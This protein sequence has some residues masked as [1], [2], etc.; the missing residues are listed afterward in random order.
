MR[1]R[2]FA[3]FC[4][5]LVT[6]S[7][8]AQPC[9]VVQC[10]TNKSVQCG[11]PWT[12]DLPTATTCCASGIVTSNGTLTNV[13]ITSTGITSNGACPRIDYT[14]TWSLVDGCG[15]STNCSQTVTVLG[16]CT[17][18]CFQVQCPT[19]KTVQ[20]GTT[21]TFDQPVATTCCTALIQDPVTGVLT[22]VLVV[23]TGTTTNGI[24]P[25]VTV[26]QTWAIMDGCGNS[27]NCTQ[28]VTITGCCNTCLQ[29]QCANSKNV[30]CGTPWTFDVPVATSCCPAFIPGTTTNVLIT[31]TTTQTNGACPKLSI[32][33][34][35]VINDAC[36]N[37]TNCSQTVTV[38]GCCPCLVVQCPTNK[39]VQCGTAWSFDLPVVTTCCT[40]TIA[41]TKTNILVTPGVVVSNGSCPTV[42]M[43]ET[44]SIIDG[45]GNSTNCSQTVTV[46]GC[47]NCLVVQC[48]TNKS[49][50]CGTTW[51]FDAPVVS[52]CCTNL[53]QTSAG[54]LTNVL[55]TPT[56]VVSNGT[57]PTV[58]MTESWSIMDGCGNTTNCSQ[59]VTVLGCCNCLQVQCSTNKSVQCGTTWSFDLPVVTSCCTSNIPGT[60]TNILITPLGV[61]SNG[62]CPTVTM[63][64][65]W[66][67]MDGCGNH[68]NCSQTVTVLGCCNCLQLQ[69]PTNKSVQCGTAWSFDLPVASSCC[70]S[71]ISGTTTNILIVPGGIVTNGACPTVTQTETWSIFDGCGNRTNCSQTVTILGC[72]NCLV[73][74]CPTNK[75]VQ[76]GTVWSFNSPVASTCCSNNIA[77]TTT[78]LLV[79]TISQTT[80]GTCPKFITKTWQITDGCGNTTNCSQVVTVV[81]TTPPVIVCPSNTIVVSLNSNCNLVIPAIPVTATDNCTPVC[82][83]VYTQNPPAGTIFPGSFTCVTVTVTDLCGNS[84][85]CVVC[86]LGLPRTPPTVTCPATMTVTNCIVP[87]VPVTASAPCCPHQSLFI[88]QSPPCGTTLGPGITSI[89]VTVIDCHG[90]VTTKVVHLIISSAQSF[91]ANLTNTGVGPGGLLLPDNSV[92]PYYAL[93]ASA[94][95]AGMPTDYHSNSV[96]VS[97]LCH[98]FN[99]FP[100]SWNPSIG[101][102]KFVPWNLPPDPATSSLAVSKWIAPDYTNCG[103]DPAGAYTYTLTFTLPAG[104]NP[105]TATISGRWAADDAAGITLNGTPI[106]LAPTAIWSWTPF[107]IP[108]GVG[109]VTGLNTLKFKVTN[110]ISW[111]G[112]RVEFTN[113]VANCLTC[114]PPS[115]ISITPSQSLPVGSTAT[116]N[117]NVGGTGP[118]TYQ[119]SHNNIPIGGAT[120]PM[121]QMFGI[122]Y[123]NAGLYSVVIHGPCGVVT[124]YV[125]LR[126][127]Y[128]WWWNWGWWNVASVASPLGATFGPS[129]NLVGS[130]VAATY[131]VNTGSTEDFGLPAPGGQ[132]V[133]VMEVNPEAG[134]SIQIPQITEAGSSNDPSYTVIMD[135]YEPDTSYGTSSTLF[136]SIACCVSNLGSGG[137]DGLALTLDSSNYLH[138]TGSSGGVPFD[139]AASQP[140]AMDA[141][142]RLALVVDNP[143]GGGTATMSLAINGG[144]III[145]N[146][147]ICCIIPYTA[148]TINWNISAPTVLTAPTTATSPN[149]VF[150]VSSI[151]FHDIALTPDMIAGIGSPDQGPAPANQTSVGASPVLTA[152]LVAGNVNLTWSGSPYALQETTDLSSGD[153]M[154]SQVP[155]TE[156]GNTSGNIQ[157]TAIATP[158]APSKFYRLVFRP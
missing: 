89:T 19:N 60:T 102:Y 8:L 90:N 38:L 31:P 82:S 144:T 132:A 47:C 13:L 147:C 56:G 12:F 115:I 96:A 84:S 140:M 46:L 71:N 157:T 68:T 119:W 15:N 11:T 98:S 41:G 83:L 113:A 62:A 7:G 53:I 143:P 70:T 104:Y 91:L 136:Q 79:T 52:T 88:S 78:N 74:Q 134:A 141:W 107:T 26:T 85:S 17:S 35:W 32:T 48:P 54:T 77:G 127:T 95:P 128:P 75:T 34:N 109:F 2:V 9:F 155:Y 80:N 129:L 45:C 57:C 37:T 30:Q 123:A 33:Q 36:G 108:P 66:S 18:N 58:T 125:N 131:G 114:V 55:V 24:C 6:I 29:V 130:S 105:A 16:C 23:P 14:Q 92:D 51:A 49:V 28:V 101:C 73:V 124:G 133:N 117:V 139:S 148:S 1:I 22:N 44:W 103:C 25:S 118:F 97:D 120:S 39:S 81:D 86:V 43:T 27:T 156:T 122:G 106:P 63:T 4:Y 145:I 146:P 150:F 135:V 142:N 40:S 110:A 126:V 151:Q 59:T 100:C 42:T 112:L 99:A 20:C 111:S 64:Q 65:S 72:C 116:F 158:S 67:I 69:C 61:V 138:L 76:C 87:C 50:Q 137:Q 21:W 3:F 5:I 10:S 121:L 152:A 153:W 149:G 93:P 154:D 94:V